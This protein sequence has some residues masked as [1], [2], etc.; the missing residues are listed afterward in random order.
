MDTRASRRD[1][2]RSKKVSQFPEKYRDACDG[3]PPPY[4]GH[5]CQTRLGAGGGDVLREDTSAERSVSGWRTASVS[6]VV[7]PPPR[8][9]QKKMK[10]NYLFIVLYWIK[11]LNDAFRGSAEEL[12]WS[13]YGIWSTVK[14][15]H[16]L[17]NIPV[18][19]IISET[20]TQIRKKM[21]GGVC[22]LVK[23]SH[24]DRYLSL[25]WADEDPGI[26]CTDN[27]SWWWENTLGITQEIKITPTH[28]L[29]IS[30]YIHAAFK[31]Q[32]V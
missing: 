11:T 1:A 6:A 5:G 21:L 22:L 23:P 15:R 30:S 19:Q 29:M 14:S 32:F 25:R 13:S 2:Y 20:V 16:P 27:R 17:K 28:K 26:I 12:H 7:R 18:L 24:T 4:S 3:D 8:G 9:E 10:H 31:R